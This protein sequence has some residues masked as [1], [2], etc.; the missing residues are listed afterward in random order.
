MKESK[1]DYIIRK[2]FLIT[3]AD[4]DFEGIL[5]VSSLINFL[6]QS[7]WQHAEHLGWGVN[8]LLKKNLAWVLSGFKIEIIDYPLWKQTITVETWPKG[9]NRLFYMR[10][11]NVFNGQGNLIA[12]ATTNWLLIDIDKRRPKLIEIDNEIFHLNPDRHAIKEFVPV[13]DFTGNAN[14][15]TPFQVRYSNVDVNQHLTTTGY[16]DFIF[17]TYEPDFISKNR[18]KSLV[19]NFI[20]EVKFGA[21]VNMLKKERDNKQH[22]FQL[23]PS[24]GGNAFFKAE[25]T[26]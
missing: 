17:D 11:Y 26:F 20:K 16:I 5:R 10:D 22:L 24:P 6:I 14:N 2:E 9:I 15:I 12:R 19:S 18:P 13:I 7:A 21:Q 1:K 25:L 3:S 8:D 23:E 4:V